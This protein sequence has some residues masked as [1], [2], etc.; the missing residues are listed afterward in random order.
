VLQ[1]VAERER[2]RE[3]RKSRR[4]NIVFYILMTVRSCSVLQCFAERERG[5]ARGKWRQ[6]DVA[7]RPNDC[8]FVCECVCVC[9]CVCVCGCAC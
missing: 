4:V 1:C 2:G 6:V 5:N 8:V 9:V 7:L 3:K